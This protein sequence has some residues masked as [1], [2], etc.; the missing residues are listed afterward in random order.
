MVPLPVYLT[1]LPWSRVALEAGV[2]TH[3]VTGIPWFDYF[4]VGGK[5]HH[6]AWG[7]PLGA[8]GVPPFLGPSA[9]PLSGLDDGVSQTVSLMN[10]MSGSR[11]GTNGDH[12]QGSTA[13]LPGPGSRNPAQSPQAL[14]CAGLVP[15]EEGSVGK[16]CPEVV[17]TVPFPW[18]RDWVLS[19]R[20]CSGHFGAHCA[21]AV[22]AA[23][24]LQALTRP[25]PHS[26]T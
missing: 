17:G 5:Q 1:L 4:R 13:G 9:Q 26:W 18:S 11:T 20:S 12:H 7:W 15:E 14:C 16:P 3:G 21:G 22:G 6:L 25:C 24:G 2:C 10:G 23:W 19:R 8:G